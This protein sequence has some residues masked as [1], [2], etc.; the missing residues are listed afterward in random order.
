VAGLLAGISLAGLAVAS[1]K[2]PPGTG[3]MGAD[4]TFTPRAVGELDIAPLQPLV[5]G[6]G[7]RP[8]EEGEARVVSIRNQTGTDLRVQ[9]RGTPSGTELDDL[10][11]VRL[12]GPGVELFRGPLRGLRSWSEASVAL[13]PGSSADVALAAWLPASVE[14]GYEGRAAAVDLDFRVDPVE[15]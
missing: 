5:L 15:G 13:S 6:R 14:R 2:V 1:W 8:A 3:I 12:T 11:W 7:L 9:V 4:V 10:V